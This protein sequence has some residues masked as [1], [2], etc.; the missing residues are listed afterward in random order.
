MSLQIRCSTLDETTFGKVLART[1][2]PWRRHLVGTALAAVTTA[3]LLAT[4]AEAHDRCDSLAN[5]TTAAGVFWPPAAGF[6]VGYY[7]AKFVDESTRTGDVD[8]DVLDCGEEISLSLE[9]YD[10]L[11]G[12]TD[13]DRFFYPYWKATGAFVQASRDFNVTKARWQE[14]R[15]AVLAA[16]VDGKPKLAAQIQL[17]VNVAHAEL[18]TRFSEYED[19]HDVYAVVIGEAARTYEKRSLSFVPP[20]GVDD[21]VET[22]RATLDG[23]VP[24]FEVRFWVDIGCTPPAFIDAEGL[25]APAD[26]FVNDD[27]PPGTFMDAETLASPATMLQS[28]ATTLS[29]VVK[30]DLVRLLPDGFANNAELP[31]PCLG[32]LDHDGAVGSSDLG[33]LVGSW[34]FCQ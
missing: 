10:R 12:Y 25:L 29:T 20:L 8:P 32:D 1:A 11:V 21:V 31:V 33:L 22:M 7:L 19:A 4:P 27:V 30:A 3:G 17:E 5:A 16:R 23:D 34:G 6:Q 14:L 9:D 2:R 15:E 13:P 26:R 24:E 18:A 28:I